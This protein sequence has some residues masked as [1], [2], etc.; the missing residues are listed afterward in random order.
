[1]TEFFNF[2]FPPFN[3]LTDAERQKFSD[4]L[5]IG[6]FQEGEVLIEPGDPVQ[7]LF[8]LIKGIVHKTT[9]GETD[10]VYGAEDAF[11]VAALIEG[12]NASRFTVEEEAL[13]YLLP[14]ATFRDLMRQNEEFNSFFSKSISAKL[15]HH[16]QQQAAPTATSLLAQKVGKVV[17][18]APRSIPATA[19]ISQAARIMRDHATMSVLVTGDDGAVIGLITSSRLRDCALIEGRPVDTPVGEVC[20]KTLIGV[21]ADDPVSEAMIQ[22]VKHKIS[23]VVVREQGAITGVMD[24]TDLLGFLSNQSYL[25][26]LQVERARDS[27]ELQEVA[28]RLNDLVGSLVESGTRIALIARLVSEI[29]QRL[30]AKLFQF[31]APAGLAEN[32]CLVVMGSEGRGEQILRTDQDNALIVA[33]GYDLEEARRFAVAFSAALESFGFPPC[34]GG[35]MVSNPDWCVSMHDF[36]QK[37]GQWVHHPSETDMISLAAFVD[38]LATAGNPEL[39]KQA[40]AHLHDILGDHDGFLAIFAK[41]V[42]AFDVP[43]GMFHQ[44]KLDRG[45]HR[46]A[47]D[48][49]K[50][51]IFPIVH[52]ARAMALKHGISATHTPARIAGLADLGIIERRFADDLVDA[53]EFMLGLK[54]RASFNSDGSFREATT[55]V[56][57]TTLHKLEKDLLKD[58]LG[59]A[60][61][62]QGIV[63]HHF[64][65]GRF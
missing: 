22:M 21:E 33:D 63:S 38:A 56:P 4:A 35:M 44:L 24:V 5:D 27:E 45:E 52:G 58:S 65:L 26:L 23:R 8:I 25:L 11:G 37:L 20:L 62:F 59:L 1:M 41:A 30:F 55:F 43:I 14:A 15:S 47:L 60:K 31:L 2:D 3:L 19:P 12:E 64:N 36:R 48:L 13:I 51:G 29:N 42:E 39:L 10:N 46:G 32:A 16:P 28:S 17:H 57:V 6:Y 34:P 40:K 9:G 7:S 54:V 53:F 61:E 49:K 50:G 18:P